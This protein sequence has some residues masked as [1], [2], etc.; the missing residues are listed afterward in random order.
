[1]PKQPVDNSA[2]HYLSIISEGPLI[3]VRTPFPMPKWRLVLK[4]LTPVMHSHGYLQKQIHTIEGLVNYP[5]DRNVSDGQLLD[6]LADAFAGGPKY[7]KHFWLYDWTTDRF[8][9]SRKPVKKEVDH[10]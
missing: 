9:L 2:V 5:E 4:G 8:T 7:F 3:I 10:A 1:M 6:K